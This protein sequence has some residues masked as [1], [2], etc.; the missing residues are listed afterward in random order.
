MWAVTAYVWTFKA[1]MEIVI[2]AVWAVTSM[3]RAGTTWAVKPSLRF[4]AGTMGDTGCAG[5]AAEALCGLLQPL[6][7]LLQHSMW[8]VTSSNWA[9]AVVEPR[10]R[11][12]KIYKIS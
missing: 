10:T 4:V 9:V 8:A 6:C 1:D 2:G 12:I 3:G 7:G 11:S 5:W